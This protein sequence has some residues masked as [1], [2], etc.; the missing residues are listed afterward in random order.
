MPNWPIPFTMSLF[1]CL[2]KFFSWV[3]GG[4]TRKRA[5]ENDCNT[6]L[7]P[8]KRQRCNHDKMQNGRD[9]IEVEDGE[10]DVQFC[11][12]VCHNSRH[13]SRQ[14]GTTAKRYSSSYFNNNSNL[15]HSTN[16]P[17]FSMPSF[18]GKSVLNSRP[19][20][21]YRH[22]TLSRSLQLKEKEEYGQ[23][24]QNFLPQRVQILQPKL[25]KNQQK[26]IEI[27]DVENYK[28]KSISKTP[29]VFYTPRTT[30]T[31][32]YTPM[33]RPLRKPV[34]KIKKLPIPEI[35]IDDGDESPI[36]SVVISSKEQNNSRI[37]LIPQAGEIVTTNS[38]RD[39]LAAKAVMKND[40]IPRVANNYNG[41][42]EQRHREAEE[43]EARTR[44]LAKRNRLQR[45]VA[46]E[47]QLSQSLK[48]CEGVL[49]EADYE[50]EGLPELTPSMLEA[51]KKALNPRPADEVL[52]EAFGLSITRK[53][54]HTL[55]GLNWL[56]D[57]V[58]NFYMNLL[59]A[60]SGKD[61]YPKIYA[62]NTFFYP[63]LLSGGHSSLKRWTRKVDI[64]S[65][66]I[67]V[68]PI[69]LGMH[70]CMSIIDFRDQSIR[71]YDSMGG[72]N[73]K[74]LIALKKY[75]E[76]ESLDKKKKAYDTRAWNLESMSGIPQQMN[77]SDCGVFS[78]T[79][80]EY[81]CANRELNFAQDNM[82]Y[83]RS[84]MVYEILNVKLL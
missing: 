83:F 50:D 52:V 29:E 59:I 13:K 27:I 84:K 28:S 11:E 56:N 82:P 40:F 19:N 12:E 14:T 54:I 24:L 32:W 3:D 21:G 45:E 43:L 73:P 1:D 69:H 37:E 77:G 81:I 53:D 17:S 22:S 74:C 62:M 70:W 18:R 20:R 78:C 64:F 61:K 26:P 55:A 34:T 58:I 31:R 60:R 36:E 41:R 71:Y 57:E 67:V 72:E 25:A 66:D 65:Q 68:V 6:Y 46:L 8:T 9:I 4:D 30:P 23:M 2:R 48:I 63:K 76:D 51:V 80:A 39:R 38:L 79:F 16:H 10:D 35:K 5:A 49:E 75:L 42:I 33:N 7:S 15:N 47:K 44:I